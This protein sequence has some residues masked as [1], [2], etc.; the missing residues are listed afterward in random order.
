N[1]QLI[2]IIDDE[3]PAFFHQT[4]IFIGSLRRDFD[5]LYE[6]LSLRVRNISETPP[7]FTG[8]AGFTGCSKSC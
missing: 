1:T 3:N 4:P 6:N 7:R 8:T 5:W 2:V